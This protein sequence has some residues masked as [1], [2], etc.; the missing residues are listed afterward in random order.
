MTQQ[1]A[2][3]RFSGPDWANYISAFSE[4]EVMRIDER[5]NAEGKLIALWQT[6]H[7]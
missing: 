7:E 2:Y 5:Y 1:A 3:E 6:E 4:G